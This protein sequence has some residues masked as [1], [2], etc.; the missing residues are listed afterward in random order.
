M[1]LVIF[2]ESEL[3]L[4]FDFIGKYIK[5]EFERHFTFFVPTI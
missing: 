4:Y 3:G 1:R 5:N 2:A